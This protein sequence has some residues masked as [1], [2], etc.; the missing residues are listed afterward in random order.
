MSRLH[1]YYKATIVPQLVKQFGYKSPME[2]PRITKI[3]LNMG[4]GEAVADKKIMEHAVVARG[5]AEEFWRKTSRRPARQRRPSW[6]RSF[7]RITAASPVENSRR[8]AHSPRLGHGARRISSASIGP[9]FVAAVAAGEFASATSK[10][11]PPGER[12]QAAPPSVRRR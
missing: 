7:C 5:R 1:D 10:L 8:N 11:R 3:T 12:K 4:V 2:V 6:Q 9:P